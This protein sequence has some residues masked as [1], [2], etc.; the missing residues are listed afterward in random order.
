MKENKKKEHIRRNKSVFSEGLLLFLFRLI[1]NVEALRLK[2]RN[3]K[4]DG[5]FKLKLY[6]PSIYFSFK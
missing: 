1:F 5:V 2:A 6:L 3:M 4:R